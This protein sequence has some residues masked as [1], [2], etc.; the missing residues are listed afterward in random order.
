MPLQESNV[1]ILPAHLLLMST[2][3]KRLLVDVLN[4]DQLQMIG[5]NQCYRIILFMNCKKEMP[6]GIL[7]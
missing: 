5:V 3:L 7:Y 1:T 4:R 2:F 6:L